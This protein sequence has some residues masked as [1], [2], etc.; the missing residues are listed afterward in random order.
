MLSL[1]SQIIMNFLAIGAGLI[2]AYI[3]YL[4]SIQSNV[5]QQI[6]LEG[7]KIISLYRE[8][9]TYR[10]PG[11]QQ[12]DI[13]I[14]D[15]KQNNPKKP[16]FEV[17]KDIAL[18]LSGIIANVDDGEI[19]I[20]PNS[21]LFKH[22]HRFSQQCSIGPIFV[23]LI[24]HYVAHFSRTP[25]INVIAHSMVHEDDFID[26]SELRL[27]PYGIG[28]VERWS[29]ETLIMMESMD[30]CFNKV[31]VILHDLNACRKDPND[32]TVMFPFSEWLNETTHVFAGIRDSN[33][34]IQS[35]LRLK[36]NYSREIRLPDLKW[37]LL[38]WSMTLFSGVL[39][40]LVISGMKWEADVPSF[41]NIIILLCT[42]VLLAGGTILCA[43]DIITNSNSYEANVYFTSLKDQLVK[44]TKYEY[45][46]YELDVVNHILSEKRKINDNIK[47]LIEEYRSMA[48]E[49]NNCSLIML[50][51]ISLALKESAILNRGYE[52]KLVVSGSGTR[53]VDVINLLNRSSRHA[54]FETMKN[55]P[56]KFEFSYQGL[57]WTRV[58]IQL[59]PPEDPEQFKEVTE[60]LELIFDQFSAEPNVKAC[61]EKRQGL[62]TISEKLYKQLRNLLTR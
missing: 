10:I 30:Y 51:Q 43:K 54:F 33:L 60:E 59:V 49:V 29:Q 31:D 47:K 55:Q 26:E 34:T 21:I 58:A 53:G 44:Y 5:D 61:L 6:Q 24:K 36:N 41:V 13:I 28:D 19:Y 12:F 17:L 42:T 27:F 7:I 3:V 39:I 18:D 32:H 22:Q 56:S 9:G 57:H 52:N 1:L 23:W 50:N 16:E 40:P 14:E 4:Y 35:L 37:I 2:G 46:S 20:S 15:Y 38:L 11:F 48:I 8:E 25:P 45:A 62:K